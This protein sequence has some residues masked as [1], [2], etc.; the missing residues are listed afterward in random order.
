MFETM[1]PDMNAYR[2]KAKK[3]LEEPMPENL[4]KQRDGGGGK[5]LDYVGGSTVIRKLNAAFDNLWDWTI[6]SFQIIPSEPKKISKQWNPTTRRSETLTTP[7]FEPQFPV[8]HVMGTLTAPG[9]G[10]RMGFGSK[11]VMGGASDQE[12]CF[13]AASTDALKKASTLFGIALELYEDEPVDFNIYDEDEPKEQAEIVEKKVIVK[14]IVEKKNDM[15]ARSTIVIPKKDK[16]EPQKVVET[17]KPATIAAFD[18]D[19]FKKIQLLAKEL[20]ITG[21]VSLGEYIAEMTK[22]KQKAWTDL[23]AADLPQLKDYL[24]KLVTELQGHMKKLAIQDLSGF[25]AYI[26]DFSENA[27]TEFTNLNP[28]HLRSFMIYL[29]KQV[30]TK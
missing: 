22:G 16:E 3:I 26:K 6:T 9:F 18:M 20:G 13:K 15:P 19:E 7:I 30:E 1:I 2:N 23:G 17:K 28:T 24:Q 5:M 8:A 11:V 27:I 10:S 21:S 14:K 25:N 4:I 12:S 29:E